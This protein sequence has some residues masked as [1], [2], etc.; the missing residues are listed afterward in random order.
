MRLHG[1]G[2]AVPRDAADFEGFARHFSGGLGVGERSVIVVD[3]ERISDP[4]GYGVRLMGF[5]SH[6]PTMDQWSQRQGLDEIGEYWAQ[7]N[8]VSFDDLDGID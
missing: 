2:R 6:R 8:R 1:R 7:K 3:V 5:E 4:C